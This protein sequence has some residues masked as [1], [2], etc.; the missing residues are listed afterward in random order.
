MAAIRCWHLHNYTL[1]R[2]WKTLKFIWGHVSCHLTDTEAFILL[3]PLL[4]SQLSDLFPT[5]AQKNKIKK[6]VKVPGNSSEEWVLGHICIY[7]QTKVMQNSWGKG[8]CVPKISEWWI[9]YNKKRFNPS[10]VCAVCIHVQ[11]MKQKDWSAV[12]MERVKISPLACSWW[13]RDQQ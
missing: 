7:T 13:F 11:A 8:F 3:S 9:K 1:S 5:R 10:T 4:W 2:L 12:V 6:K